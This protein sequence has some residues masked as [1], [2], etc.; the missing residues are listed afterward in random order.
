[1]KKQKENATAPSMK[2]CST[3]AKVVGIIEEEV[4]EAAVVEKALDGDGVV[5]VVGAVAVA[6]A[7]VDGDGEEEEEVVV[8]GNGGVMENQGMVKEKEE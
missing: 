8:G 4:E 7:V 6:V 3:Q 2:L 1:M 5:E